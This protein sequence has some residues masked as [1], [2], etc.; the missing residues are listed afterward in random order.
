[1]SL[2]DLDDACS[3]FCSSDYT[4]LNSSQFI[5]SVNSSQDIS[6][7][8]F[9]ETEVAEDRTEEFNRTYGVEDSGEDELF[10]AQAVED[11]QDTVDDA[12]GEKP[13]RP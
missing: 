4:R 1:L 2:N 12:V 11:D 13:V 6:R 8:S 5:R 3:S 9:D 10:L 7:G